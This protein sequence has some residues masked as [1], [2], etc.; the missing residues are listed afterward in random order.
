MKTLPSFGPALKNLHSYVP[1]QENMFNI[2]DIHLFKYVEV[3]KSDRNPTEIL[4]ILLLPAKHHSGG[5]WVGSRTV[6]K[7]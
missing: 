7:C 5:L 3:Q 2:Y 4:G 6:C 1:A